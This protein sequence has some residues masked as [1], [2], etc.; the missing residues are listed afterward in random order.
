MIPMNP[1]ISG[2]L[3]L[4]GGIRAAIFLALALCL[5]ATSAAWQ[6]KAHKAQAELF[7]ARN[8]LVIADERYSALTRDLADAK[9]AGAKAV[10]ERIQ[11]EKDAAKKLADTNKAWRKTY[12][13]KPE[14]RR[15]ADTRLPPDI[16]DKLRKRP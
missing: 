14:N 4:V 9:A 8:E 16:G 11:A 13:A 7:Q 1:F 6:H 10:S 15:W 5:L 2:A 12:D 3:A